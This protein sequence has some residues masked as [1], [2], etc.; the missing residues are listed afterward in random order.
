MKSLLVTASVLL[1]IFSC[2]Q[3]NSKQGWTDTNLK[4]F[5]DKVNMQNFAYDLFSDDLKE[6]YNNCVFPKIAQKY[7]Y[8]EV[9]DINLK[10]TLDNVSKFLNK[11]TQQ[12]WEQLLKDNV[13]EFKSRG[14]EVVFPK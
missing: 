13:D 1:I 12:C 4:E 6:E 7:S 3:S 2:S 9:K 8:Q 10:D 5:K 14:M 11:T